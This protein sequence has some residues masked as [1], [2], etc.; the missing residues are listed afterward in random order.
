MS[1][2]DAQFNS[3]AA[4]QDL[5]RAAHAPRYTYAAPNGARAVLDHALVWSTVTAQ[6][7]S[8]AVSSIHPSHDHS[9]LYTKVPS[10]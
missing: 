10:S 8:Y 6:F 4:S 1:A 3:W 9:T 7:S 5:T 2:I